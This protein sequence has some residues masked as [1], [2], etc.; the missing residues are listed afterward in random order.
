MKFS[1]GEL[2]NAPPLGRPTEV[3]S[4]QIKTLTENNECYTTW[5]IADILK[6]AKS[7]VA[8]HLHQLGYVNLF[9][10][11]VLHK[12]SKKNLLDYIST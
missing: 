12:L 2:E 5:E 8:N 4:D 11:W 6:I 3:D 9:Y 1:A 7:I 10:V